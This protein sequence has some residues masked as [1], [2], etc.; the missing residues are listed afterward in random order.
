M[1]KKINGQNK[2]LKKDS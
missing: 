1:I 2:I